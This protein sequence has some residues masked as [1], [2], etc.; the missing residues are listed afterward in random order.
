MVLAHLG[1][2]PY[3]VKKGDQIAQLR[4]EKIDNRDP[5]EVTQLDDT[6]GGDQ[7]FGSSDTTTAQRVTGQ[8]AKPYMEINK[9]SA[10]AFGQFEQRG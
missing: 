6:E 4:I 10:R 7:R 2:Q 8:K 1:D 9:I 5:E 3:R